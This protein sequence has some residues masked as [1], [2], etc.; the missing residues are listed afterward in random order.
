MHSAVLTGESSS[1]HREDCEGNA[2][3]PLFFLPMPF[4]KQLKYA[5]NNWVRVQSLRLRAWKQGRKAAG[6]PVFFSLKN[7][8]EAPIRES[9]LGSSFRPCFSGNWNKILSRGPGLVVPLSIEATHSANQLRE[10]FPDEFRYLQPPTVIVELC[11]NKQRFNTWLEEAGFSQ[12]LPTVYPCLDKAVFPCVIKKAVDAF[13]KNAFVVQDREAA[14]NLNLTCLDEYVIQECITGTT[15][16]A[17]HFYRDTHQGISFAKTIVYEF[18]RPFFIKGAKHRPAITAID[19]FVAGE[20]LI[21]ILEAMSYIGVGCY[22]FKF[23][24]STPKIFEINPRVGA[25]LTPYIK[26]LLEAVR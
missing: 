16:Y 18:D 22:N 9:L 20:A 6:I 1:Y 26:E 8:W 13:G 21:P 3:T 10:G 24:G 2:P 14:E 19:N 17:V 7:D 12:F 25:S 11:D 5:F 4:L 15:E 23:V